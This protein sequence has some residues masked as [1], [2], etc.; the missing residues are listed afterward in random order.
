MLS[1]QPEKKSKVRHRNTSDCIRLRFSA[2][3]FFKVRRVPKKS[4]IDVESAEYCSR[5]HI[6][7]ILSSTSINALILS[8]TGFWNAFYLLPTKV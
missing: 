8:P 6:D 1:I 4:A 3:K 7:K 5:K 2:V